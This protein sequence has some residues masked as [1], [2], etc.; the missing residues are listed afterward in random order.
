MSVLGIIAE[1]NPLHNGH[2]YFISQARQAHDFD[3]AIC[4]MSGNFVQRG[5]AAICNKWVRTLMAL[6]AGVDLVI[7]IPAC[8]CVRSAYYFARGAIQ[9]LH[10]TGVVTHLA[11]GSENGRLDELAA[12]AA[13]IGDESCQ[14]KHHLKSCL[15]QG[16]SYPTARA[17]TIESIAGNRF[18][19]LG[20]IIGRPNNILAIE[21]LRVLEQE[22]IS[23]KPLTIPRIGSQYDSREI[24]VMASASAIRHRLLSDAGNMVATT[25]PTA[26]FIL[27]QQEI[28]AGRAPVATTT[29]GQILL[30]KLRMIQPDQLRQI[31]EVSEGLENRMLKAGMACGTWDELRESIKSKRYSLTRINRMLLYVLL[32]LQTR[33]M[34]VFDQHGPLYIHILGFSTKGRKILQDIKNKSDLRILSRGS[35]VKAAADDDDSPV[36]RNMLRLDVMATDLYCLLYP[37]A[38]QRYGAR[39]FTTSPQLVTGE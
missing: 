24:S 10:R 7:E 5:E 4:V 21:Y 27:L 8:F 17:R 15:A 18:T 22:Q 31:Y 25:M 32:N 1:F 33:Q 34:L 28:E 19:G 6:H 16:L 23:I 26:A 39:D 3:A 37:Q 2:R 36:L 30:A 9:L 20:S 29:L 12:L 14:Y 38:Q 11:F 35:A 13:I